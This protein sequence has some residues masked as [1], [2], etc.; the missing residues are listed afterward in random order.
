MNPV[1][2]LEKRQACMVTTTPQGLVKCY[3]LNSLLMSVYIDNFYLS[4]F[5]RRPLW[6]RSCRQ[7]TL[8]PWKH[9]RWLGDQR[10]A[11]DTKELLLVGFPRQRLSAPEAFQRSHPEVGIS[12]RLW[13]IYSGHGQVG[14]IGQIA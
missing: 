14:F 6:F 11:S 12:C 2:Q 10:L 9:G 4:R 3:F 5:P 7:R 1:S 8:L 13:E